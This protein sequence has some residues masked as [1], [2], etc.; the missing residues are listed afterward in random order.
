MSFTLRQAR[1]CMSTYS[2]RLRPAKTVAGSEDS[3]LLKSQSLL[4]GGGRK[5]SGVHS[6]AIAAPLRV[7]QCVCARVSAAQVRAYL[8]KQPRQSS[9]HTTTVIDIKCKEYAFQVAGIHF[10]SNSLNTCY[11][12]NEVLVPHNAFAKH[13]SR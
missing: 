6:F 12:V 1:L 3:W 7:R 11:A 9:T 4:W 10:I 5:Q 8:N 2:R 13:A